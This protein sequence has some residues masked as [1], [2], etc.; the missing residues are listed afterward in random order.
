MRL[1][2]FLLLAGCATQIREARAVQPNPVRDLGSSDRLP[3]SVPLFVF[4]RDSTTYNDPLRAAPGRG[5]AIRQEADIDFSAGIPRYWQLRNYA[6]FVV[7]SRDRLVFHV[8]VVRR[9][10]RDAATKGWTVWLEDDAGHKLQPEARENAK[11]DRLL[12][13]WSRY[14]DEHLNQ[15]MKKRELPG[16]DAFQGRCDYTFTA[17]DLMTSQRRALA[18]VMEREGYQ[19]R[20]A[21]SFDEGLLVEAQH[22]GRS[23]TDI[24]TG[25][26]VAPSPDTQVAETWD[27]GHEP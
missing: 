17:P 20:F 11:V 25:V 18:L 26:M 16:W 15:Y 3:A 23:K 19:M 21:W 12:L 5:A 4:V 7:V 24:D 27:E 13:P 22:Y 8:A 1:A 2:V 10:V 6:Q 14:W 9:D